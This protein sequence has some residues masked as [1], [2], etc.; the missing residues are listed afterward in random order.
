[1]TI[2]DSAN[3]FEEI[4]TGFSIGPL[5]SWAMIAIDPATKEGLDRVATT[6]VWEDRKDVWFDYHFGEGEQVEERFA[7]I[8]VDSPENYAG[9]QRAKLLDELIE[10]VPDGVA[11]SGKRVAESSPS[12]EER[13]SIPRSRTDARPLMTA[14][15]AVMASGLRRAGSCPGKMTLQL[16]LSSLE[17]IAIE[18]SR[19]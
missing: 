6:N 13:T 16:L 7:K 1:M 15:S 11:K 14:S 8:R 5:A 10:L 3:H 4:R 9:I 12:L 18:V 17:S 2:Y 19:R